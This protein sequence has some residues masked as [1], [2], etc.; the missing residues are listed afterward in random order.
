MVDQ[1]LKKRS[2]KM[3]GEQSEGEDSTVETEG[4][5]VGEDIG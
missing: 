1:K 5:P 4:V 2:K 3:R